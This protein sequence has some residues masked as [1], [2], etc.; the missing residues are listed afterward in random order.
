MVPIAALHEMPTLSCRQAI[1]HHPRPCSPIPVGVRKRDTSRLG[2]PPH[3]WVRASIGHAGRLRS[4]WL[5]SSRRLLHSPLLIGC[6]HVAPLRGILSNSIAKIQAWGMSARSHFAITRQ[7]RVVRQVFPVPLPVAGPIRVRNPLG[8]CR[9][10]SRIT[11]VLRALYGSKENQYRFRGPIRSHKRTRKR[12]RVQWA[13]HPDSSTRCLLHTIA[14]HGV[15]GPFALRNASL[16]VANASSGTSNASSEAS[17]G[18]FPVADASFLH[19][20]ASFSTASNAS[21]LV[22]S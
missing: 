7:F 5:D 9:P 18:S 22:P 17:N 11:S 10:R 3:P 13:L 4:N 21:R 2:P 19:E 20:N 12:I 14:L 16:G 15:S 1:Q 8:A 6:D